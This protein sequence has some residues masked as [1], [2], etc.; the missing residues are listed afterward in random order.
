MYASRLLALLYASLAVA[1]HQPR[2]IAAASLWPSQLRS[3]V[4][5]S[6]LWRFTGGIV[7]VSTDAGARW[8]TVDSLGHTITSFQID[9]NFPESRAFAV[10]GER[11]RLFQTVN[12]GRTWTQMPSDVSLWDVVE[13]EADP[14]RTLQL[15]VVTNPF[16][17]D[18]IIVIPMSECIKNSFCNKSRSTF[19]STDGQNLRLMTGLKPPKGRV[20]FKRCDF[21]GASAA[22]KVICNFH[23]DVSS[24]TR[25]HEDVFLFHSVDHGRSFKPPK[26]F[27]P[28]TVL[29]QG[30]AGGYDVVVTD[31]KK[32]VRGTP[33][34]RL[35]LSRDAVNYENAEV[36][37]DYRKPTVWSLG[38]SPRRL[39]VR[40]VRVVEGELREELLV[41]NAQGPLLTSLVTLD[42]YAKSVTFIDTDADHVTTI[43]HG[44]HTQSMTALPV[45]KGDTMITFDD[46]HEWSRLQLRDPTGEFGCDPARTDSC[47]VNT[48]SPQILD[49]KEEYIL[50]G[51]AMN[52]TANSRY[53]EFLS[54]YTDPP[55]QSGVLGVSAVIGVAVTVNGT[56]RSTSRPLTFLTTDGG[57][58]WQKMLD[59][60]AKV[61]F[62]NY[63]TLI[64]AVPFSNGP[65]ISHF[66]Y[67]MDQGRSWST[68]EF[69]QP[70]PVFSLEPVS[71]DASSTVFI[72]SE[73]PW[74]SGCGNHIIN[75]SEVLAG[76]SATSGAGP[77]V[78][79][80]P[81]AERQQVLGLGLRS[82]WK[83]LRA[84]M[85]RDRDA[86]VAHKS[87]HWR[88]SRLWGTSEI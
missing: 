50:E 10:D 67:S 72:A 44:W 38:D 73:R 16:V 53:G 11:G 84:P 45:N 78:A 87:E 34:Y 27:K 19:T 36:L 4:G 14:N 13:N 41:S 3:F 1:V 66:Y 71:G 6:D 60:P 64:A 12:Q 52:R 63:G 25:R 58:S 76:P 5:S 77:G 57:H 35:W 75:F 51:T 65:N 18:D 20:W 26:N 69:T 23:M 74:E 82:D 40:T 24:W 32:K 68:G 46:G 17:R 49:L 28:R 59:F 15:T 48:M 43:L 37:S 70:F 30:K 56:S 47:F 31:G 55:R 33:M 79:H 85:Y 86:V 81:V 29:S 54:T 88:H 83:G 8:T 39:L 7:A 21:F 80:G 61:A 9:E 62:G 42:P 22:P 2:V